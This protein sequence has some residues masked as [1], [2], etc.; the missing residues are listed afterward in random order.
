MTVILFLSRPLDLSASYYNKTTLMLVISRPLDLSRPPL[1][2][3]A[4]LDQLAGQ[5]VIS[6]P[7]VYALLGIV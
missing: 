1:Y 5:E 7:D 2:S 6:K 4:D 3:E